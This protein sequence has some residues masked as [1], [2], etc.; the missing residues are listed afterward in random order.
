MKKTLQKVLDELKKD[1][2]DISYIRGILETLLENEESP[3][4]I[5]NVYP[6][7]NSNAKWV[8]TTASASPEPEIIDEG[9]ALD[10]MAQGMIKKVDM[11][12]IERTG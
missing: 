7:I 11:E 2:P 3:I 8:T 6:N 5:P 10:N 1:T 12:S 9:L 4:L